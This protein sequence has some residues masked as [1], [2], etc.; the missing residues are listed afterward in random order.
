MHQ[1]VFS[2]THSAIHNNASS[3]DLAGGLMASAVVEARRALSDAGG[4][5]SD[6]CSTAL[7]SWEV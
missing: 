6:S 3:G 2:A 4:G 1:A 7:L 5:A